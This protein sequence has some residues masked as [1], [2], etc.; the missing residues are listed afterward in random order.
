[1]PMKPHFLLFIPLLA[2]VAL[3][4]A[5]NNPWGPFDIRGIAQNLSLGQ[6]KG[7][8]ERL[9]SSVMLRAKWKNL[10]CNVEGGSL[11]YT[12]NTD[13]SDGVGA[14]ATERIVYGA[15]T[16]AGRS[17]AI[18]NMG[19]ALGD[20][21]Q[22]EAVL[23]R[24]V[25]SIYQPVAWLEFDPSTCLGAFGSD[26]R[27]RLVC[28]KSEI[29]YVNVAIANYTESVVAYEITDDGLKTSVLLQ[30]PKTI[31]PSC[32]V[33]SDFRLY[34]VGSDFRL[35]NLARWSQRNLGGDQRPDLELEVAE[36]SLKLDVGKF[37]KTNAQTGLPELQGKL[38]LPTPKRNILWFIWNGNGFSPTA[39]TAT[40]KK[41]LEAIK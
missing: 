23:L 39:A 15:F 37:C 21:A 3:A 17:E 1:M 4:A 11:G 31:M 35:Y 41:R 36:A 29:E 38:S 27:Q 30:L 25:N 2:L 7:I 32:E 40:I 16:K 24:Q 12:L 6:Q 18:V 22:T 26:Q 14:W 5:Q 33:G 19:F 9:C 28:L 20:S 34:N 8:L 10:K 13:A